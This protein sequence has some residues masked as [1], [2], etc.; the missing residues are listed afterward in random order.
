MPRVVIIGAGISGLAL[1]NRLR[2]RQ[3]G[4]D[5]T[6]LES[7]SRPGGKVRTEHRNGFVVEAGPN[8]FLETKP[9]TL[10]LCR[11]LGLGGELIAASEASRKHRFLFVNERLRALP[12]GPLGLLVTRLLGFRGKI[13]VMTELLRRGSPPQKDE[14]VAEFFRR[15]MGRQAADVLGDALVTGIHGGDPELLS[16]EAA[17]PRAAEMEAK[18]GSVIRGFLRSAKQRRQDALARGEPPPRTGT[19]WSFRQGLGRL[20][21]SLAEL[22]KS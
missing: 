19:M 13:G 1:A 15:R 18:H 14:S 17:F 7:D 4:T 5:I 10:Q 3:P 2:Q 20:V 21:D 8:G 9:S 16:L 12:G 11:D 6:L 22:N